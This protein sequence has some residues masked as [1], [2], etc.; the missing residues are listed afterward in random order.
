MNSNRPQG[1]GDEHDRIRTRG[2]PGLSEALSDLNLP[3]F[4]PDLTKSG[5]PNGLE[6]SLLTGIPE[7]QCSNPLR[8]DREYSTP[9]LGRAAI[10]FV[11][12]FPK[13]CSEI[14]TAPA[15]VGR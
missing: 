12:A 9:R 10:G 5:L 11:I 7:V 6:Q 4:E 13:G 1:G 8:C 3:D 14:P 15:M 2:Q